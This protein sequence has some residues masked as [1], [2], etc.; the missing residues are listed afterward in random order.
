NADEHPSGPSGGEGT[1]TD[2][3]SDSDNSAP[4]NTASPSAP[5]DQPDAVSPDSGHG[6]SGSAPTG[7]AT[8]DNGDPAK[9]AAITQALSASAG[10]LPGDLFAQVKT[11]LEGAGA[12][13]QRCILPRP[14]PYQ[15]SASAGLRLLARVQPESRRLMARLQGLVQASRFDRPL[16]QRS[17]TR[18]MSKRL[19]RTAL[20]DPRLFARKRER[21]GDT[22]ALC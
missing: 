4:S 16:P 18:L 8:P 20:G 17:G 1:Q 2:S 14:E 3:G 6:D 10:D 9:H 12:D 5:A 7:A 21:I 22:A 13:S 15:G 11:L 19:Y